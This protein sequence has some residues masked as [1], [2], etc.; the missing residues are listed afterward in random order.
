M[1]RRDP[2]AFTAFVLASQPG[3]R[4]TAYLMC[5]DW[6]L[7]GDHVQEALIRVWVD[8]TGTQVFVEDLETGDQHQVPVPLDDGCRLPPVKSYFQELEKQVQTRQ[9]LL[10]R[11]RRDVRARGRCLRA[12]RGQRPV[13]PTGQRST[14][15]GSSVGSGSSV[16]TPTSSRGQAVR[17]DTDDLTTG[18]VR[19]ATSAR[20]ECTPSRRRRVCTCSGTTSRAATWGSSPAERVGQTGRM[21]IVSPAINDYLLAHSEPADERTPRPRRG[22]PPRARRPGR[23]ADHPRRGRAADDAGP[24]R[25]RAA[26]RSRSA[27]SP[28]TPR[29]ASPAGCP[30]TGTCSAATS[31][32]SG[33]RSR[34]ATG[35][36]PG[37]P[38]G[39]SSGSRRPSRRCG[40]C[41]PSAPWTSRSSTP[42]RPAT[43]RTS[44]RS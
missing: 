43:R 39:S 32:R 13:G 28:A 42:T 15:P 16:T 36:G 35:S 29:S 17:L 21:D 7:A 11:G 14:G 19:L 37:S 40:R 31:A 6:Q 2:E 44:R 27:R 23:H 18:V 33:P 38:T 24:A 20:T 34:G 30:T 12:H 25:R 26:A 22:D 5:G 8:A 1:A 3:L 4:R 41:R 10:G 9:R